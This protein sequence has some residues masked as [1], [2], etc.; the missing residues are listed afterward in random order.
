MFR[1]TLVRL[2]AK[3][4][5]AAMI[6]S[7]HGRIWFMHAKGKQKGKEVM[8]LSPDLNA[9]HKDAM[10]IDCSPE[11]FDFVSWYELVPPLIG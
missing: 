1:I 9:F 6:I 10:W 8:L 5:F 3:T 4:E 7:K 2:D 11:A